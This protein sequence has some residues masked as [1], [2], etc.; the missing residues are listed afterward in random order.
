MIDSND[1]KNSE[2]TTMNYSNGKL[3][4]SVNTIDTNDVKSLFNE[5]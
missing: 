1:I 5:Q 2:S 4:T 3:S